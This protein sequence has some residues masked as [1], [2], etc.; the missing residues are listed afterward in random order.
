LVD[1]SS[2]FRIFWFRISEGKNPSKPKP[3]RFPNAAISH[4]ATAEARI[5]CKQRPAAAAAATG[6][7]SG[8]LDITQETNA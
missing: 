2:C 6:C 4:A 1:I 5:A 7:V 3:R 8:A